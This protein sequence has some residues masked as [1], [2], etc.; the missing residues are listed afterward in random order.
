MKH[1]FENIELD[2]PEG[3]YEPREDSLM[4]AEFLRKLDKKRIKVLEIGCGSGLLSILMAKAND[5]TAVDI[6]PK[7]V[8]AAKRNAAKSGMNIGCFVSDLFENVKGKYDLIIFN[9]PYLPDDDDMKGS[10]M[11]SDK[12]TISKFIKD[13]RSHLN[14]VGSVLILVSSLTTEKR[15]IKELENAGFSVKVAETRKIPWET[16]YILE[17]KI[18]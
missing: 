3:V 5:V 4:F 12:G 16:L 6:N 2:V 17:A 14:K 18:L 9:P 15:V 8:D 7:A 13:A 10:E 1:Y 11:W